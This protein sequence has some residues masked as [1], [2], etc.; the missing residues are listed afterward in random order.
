MVTFHWL[1]QLVDWTCKSENTELDLINI[2]KQWQYEWTC[3]ENLSRRELRVLSS[4]SVPA[5]QAGGI[6]SLRKWCLKCSA[7]RKGN[8]AV[9]LWINAGSHSQHSLPFQIFYF[10][11][12]KFLC[13]AKE[14]IY[15]YIRL[16]WGF[17]PEFHGVKQTFRI[18][19]TAVLPYFWQKLEE[20]FEAATGNTDPVEGWS[21]NWSR[22]VK[23]KIWCC[24]ERK[25]NQT[26]PN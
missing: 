18:N 13:S 1:Q 4:P 21:K 23:C 17:R 19:L 14:P 20:E 8:G 2:D 6:S 7:E 24:V 11:N 15:D 5:G 26:K 3:C 25:P 9:Y 16:F 12:I 10:Q 22:W